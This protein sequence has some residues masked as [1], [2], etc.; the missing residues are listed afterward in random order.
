[1]PTVLALLEQAKAHRS[2]AERARRLADSITTASVVEELGRHAAIF[3]KRAC[4]L[5]ERACAA[6]V[7]TPSRDAG[8]R[9]VLPDTEARLSEQWAGLG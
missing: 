6:A 7:A 4:E 8:A 3:E 2:S 1:M 9:A 5:E